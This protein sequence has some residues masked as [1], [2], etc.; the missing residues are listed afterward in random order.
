MNKAITE[1]HFIPSTQSDVSL[2]TELLVD[3]CYEWNAEYKCFTFEE[4]E[5]LIDNLE[6]EISNLFGD[7]VDGYF[8]V[9]AQ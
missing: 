9:E 4:D 5:D 3:F 7:Q 6:L 2:A 8:E 1:L